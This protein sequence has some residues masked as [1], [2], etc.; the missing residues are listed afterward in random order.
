MK[1]GWKKKW[2]F[3]FLCSVMSDSATPW[4][5]AR[6]PPL[7]MGFSRQE[8]WNG[9]PFPPPGDWTQVSCFFC[10]GRWIFFFFFNHW[11]TW[12]F[13]SWRSH[14]LEVFERLDFALGLALTLDMKIHRGFFLPNPN[15]NHSLKFPFLVPD[16]SSLLWLPYLCP[17]FPLVAYF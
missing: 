9:L 8:Y 13:T 11:A 6:Q 3:F 2:C 5:A 7:S 15:P 17:V 1:Q 10:I 12:S 14:F 4:T 16:L